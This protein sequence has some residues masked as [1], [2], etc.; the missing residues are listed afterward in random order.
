MKYIE[1]G[2]L[3]IFLLFPFLHPIFCFIKTILE[4]KIEKEKEKEENLLNSLTLTIIQH[5][6]LILQIIPEIISRI[7]Q[8][9]ENLDIIERKIEKNKFIFVNLTFFD[10]KVIG[11]IIVT[12]IFEAYP[13]MINSYLG[14]N[15]SIYFYLDR[16]FLLLLAAI[17]SYFILNIQIFKH[18]YLAI[19]I[20]FTSTLFI[21]IMSKSYFEIEFILTLFKLITLILICLSLVINKLI[22]EVYFVSPFMILFLQGV[23]GL[24]IDSILLFIFIMIDLFSLNDFFYYFQNVNVI[25]IIFYSLLFSITETFILLTNF[26]FSPTM[27]NVSDLISAFALDIMELLKWYKIIGYIILIIGC[28]IYNE[29]IILKFCGL[30]T[31]TQKEIILRSQIEIN[32]EENE[33]SSEDNN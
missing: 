5:A 25:T 27:V 8:K 13:E 1:I 2:I 11:L 21:I 32:I 28:F 19:I 6:G 30:D 7:R 22:L 17:E 15:D 26:Y 3:R 31:F 9:R 29:I 23:F 24:I 33:S 16:F 12:T 18:Q 20:I 4:S 10:F 14:V